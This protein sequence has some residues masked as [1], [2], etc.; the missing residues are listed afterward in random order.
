VKNLTK[1]V[2]SATEQIEEQK[3]NIANNINNPNNLKEAHV[4]TDLYNDLSK[5]VERYRHLPKLKMNNRDH[6]ALYEPT[7]QSIDYGS[8]EE[9][10]HAVNVTLYKSRPAKL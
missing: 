2:N 5:K 10:P 4:K 8:I 7:Y 3:K 1:V 6:A 9:E